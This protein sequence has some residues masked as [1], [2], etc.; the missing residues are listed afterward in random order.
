MLGQDYSL[1]TRG[2]HAQPTSQVLISTL[3]FAL[4]SSLTF[5]SN[6]RLSGDMTICRNLEF[7]DL[8]GKDTLEGDAERFAT[9]A[10]ARELVLW[11]CERITGSK[12]DLQ[13]ALPFCKISS[14]SCQQQHPITLPPS[15]RAT[16][17][18]TAPPPHR[19]APV[20]HTTP[21]RHE[22]D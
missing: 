10:K 16:V 1:I 14:V 15:H 11:D 21:G 17:P 6:R 19:S 5:K 9:F 20:H 2:Q 7:V 22:H 4:P 8:S 12:A 3:S 13:D 18:L